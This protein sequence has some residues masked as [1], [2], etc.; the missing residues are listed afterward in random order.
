MRALFAAAAMLAAGPAWAQPVGRD[1]PEVPS[2]LTVASDPN[3]VNLTTGQM[4]IDLPVLATPAAPNLRFDRLQNAA[5]HVEGKGNNLVADYSVHTGGGASEAFHCNLDGAGCESRTLS[6][7]TFNPLAFVQA[8]SVARY[9][10]TNV[11]VDTLGAPNGGKIVKYVSNV[12]YPN[13]EVISYDY[14]SAPGSGLIKTWFRPRQI[15]SSMGYRITLSYEGGNLA[16]GDFGSL[17][18]AA[19]YRTGASPVLIRRLVYSGSAITDH[20][21]NPL[22]GGGREFACTG[23]NRAMGSPIETASGSLRL[24]GEGA[25]TLQLLASIYHPDTPNDVSPSGFHSP[26]PE[27]GIPESPL[28]PQAH[29]R[30]FRWG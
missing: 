23:C 27:P 24:P 4:A 14:D 17:R 10:F 28:P 30:G 13:G 26:D 12:R 9:A 1:F 5:P 11:H 2:P 22:D 15:S 29:D 6:G 18:Q 8:G 21:D 20:G 3:G 25:D 16:A 7:S 19:L